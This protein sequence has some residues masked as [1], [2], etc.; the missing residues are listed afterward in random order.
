VQLGNSGQVSIYNFAGRADVVVDVQ[1]YFLPAP[2]G[3]GLFNPV[4]PARVLD[5]RPGSGLQHG[6]KTMT[7]GNT[8]TFKVAGLGNVP[9]SGVSSVVLNVTVTDPTSSSFLTVYPAGVARP[10]ASNLNFVAGQTIPNRVTVPVGTNGSVTLYNHAGRV[11]VLADVG[12]WYTDTSNPAASGSTFTGMT[13]VRITDTRPGSGSLNAGRT[14]GSEGVL[15]MRVA[16]VGSVPSMSSGTPPKA[17]VLNVTVTE[18]SATSFLTVYPGRT[19]RPSASDLNWVPG[20]TV[21]NLVVVKVGADGT[22]DLYNR[23]GSVDAVVDAVGW[24]A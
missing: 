5:T 13:P 17:V 21:P 19:S 23:F 14:L 10:V 20:L 16:G 6:G 3:S 9:A 22:V 15:N 7:A 1:G 24:Y 18:P 4:A 11:D 8:L 12:G 2:V